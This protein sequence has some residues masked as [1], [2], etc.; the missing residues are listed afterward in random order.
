MNQTPWEAYGSTGRSETSTLSRVLVVGSLILIG[1]LAWKLWFGTSG[2][3]F[4]PKAAPRTVAPRGD[5]GSDEQATISLFEQSAP[6]VLHITNMALAGYRRLDYTEI[7]QGSGTGFIWNDQG[8]IVTNNHVVKDGDTFEVILSD[9]SS[10]N[11]ILVGTAPELDIAVLKIPDAPRSK[12]R[13]LSIGA[14]NDLRVGQKVLA[15]GNPFGLDQT[16]TTG[17][18]SGLNRQIKSAEG[19]EIN[20]VIQTDAAINPGNSGGPLLDSAGR[21]IGM[22]TAIVSPSGA[23][24]GIGFALPVDV[25][26]QVVPELI[27]HGRRERPAIGINLAPDE[28]MERLVRFNRVPKSGAMIESILPRSAA[29]KAGLRGITP[30]GA[31]RYRL[32]DI[33]LAIDSRPIQR[34][35]DVAAALSDK[36]VG[37]SIQ[38]KILRD[39]TEMDVPIVLQ[40]RPLKD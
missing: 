33:V 38:V 28:Q 2:T 20:G 26:N 32:G 7:P 18:I 39:G 13:P 19:N 15:I 34:A 36:N 1:M 21:L 9:G 3:L 14:S 25:I 31:G 35:T 17:V 40:A 16:L 5:L 10:Y 27:R 8:H 12:L 23:Y 4:D 30:D 6:S 11:G 29:A 37:D 24:A 22:N